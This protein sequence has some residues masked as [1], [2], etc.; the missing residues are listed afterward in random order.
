MTDAS[1]SASPFARLGALITGRPHRPRQEG[2]GNL[3][4]ILR[5][6][7]DQGRR[8]WRGY[9]IAFSCMGV[10]AFTTSA[11]A[12]IMGDVIDKVFIGK[13]YAAVWLIAGA[14]VA[15]SVVKGLASYGQQVVL[16]RIANSIVADVQRRIF[17]KMLAMRVASFTATHSTDF[18]ARQ[19]FI[20]R[21]ASS[22]LN[23]LI[24]A[25]ARDALTLVGLA[26]VMVLQ[27]PIMAGL[28]LLIM[29]AA[30]L[31][32]RKLSGRVRKV[33]M[34]EFS[35]FALIMESLQ[36]TA[37]GIRVVKAFTLEPQR[38]AAQ[39]A[40]I[41]SLQ[42]AADKV[43]K[44]G[45]RSS[46]LM[47]TLG[48]VAVALV[49]IYGGWRVID[50]GQA[51]GA[52]FS[53]I[54]AL[55]LAYEPA[56][57]IA[58]LQIDLSASLLG[59]GMLYDF[60]D[61]SSDEGDET[62]RTALAPGPGRLELRQAGFAYRPG[63]PVLRGLDLVAEAGRTTAL[64]GRS[65]AGKSTIMSLILRYYETGAGQ[66]L[67]DGQ[68]ISKVTRASLRQAISYVSQETFL[69]T[70][71]V[72]DNIALG[73]PGATQ[74]EIEAAARAAHAHEFIQ[75]FERGYDT[76]CGEHGMQLSGGQRQRIAIARAFLKNA[77]ILLLDEATSALDSESERAVEEALER[78]R[79]GRTTLVIA[80]RLSTIR[81]ADRIA[82]VQDGRVV[83]HGS[84]DQLLAQQSVY[85][86][87]VGTQV[88][89]L[90]KT[91]PFK[92]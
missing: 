4:L 17:D 72:R 84:H 52:F 55:L 18:I 10:V 60:M 65:G 42:A 28:A 45:A 24:T 71:S 61:Q 23:L 67:I 69:F 66:I 35:G 31:G 1:T 82:V 50:G 40:A 88:D 19:S 32:T 36:E 6:L 29:P 48:G 86:A 76:P 25:L 53:F 73:R 79:Q 21:C 2:P 22:A 68:D 74:D 59:V 43:A 77:P 83:E 7:D 11:T 34:T 9:A 30:I 81:S 44:I 16:A 15:I 27:D 3:A 13:D 70:G 33:F 51:P 63:E 80:H 92:L 54:T 75:D 87:M 41:A 91:K 56:K 78:L 90:S 46:P 57:R 64:V 89:G 58:R 26:A 5:L 12:W 49:V 38:R 62:G 14:M 47:E 20:T 37:Q 39:A 85:A 8:Q